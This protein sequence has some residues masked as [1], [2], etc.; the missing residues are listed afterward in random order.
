MLFQPQLCR[1]IQSGR[2]TQTRRLVKPGKAGA[3]PRCFYRIGSS[4]PLE[5]PM[6]LDE[7]DENQAKVI[8]RERPGRPPK[9]QI[10]RVLIT[11]V[12]RL[13]LR[14]L[15]FDAARAEGFPR[16]SA[17][18]A[19]WVRMH[20]GTWVRRFTHDPAPG[21][22]PMIEPPSEDALVARYD[23]RWGAVE[24]WAITF[25]LVESAYY[26]AARPERVGNDYVT[27]ERDEKGREVAMMTLAEVARAVHP[28]FLQTEETIGRFPEEAVHPGIIESWASEPR[29]THA[30]IK[31][32]TRARGDITEAEQ[33]SVDRRLLATEE[34]IRDR[35]SAAKGIARANGH[36][37]SN[38]IK[39]LRADQAYHR[40]PEAI[41]EGLRAVERAATPTSIREAKHAA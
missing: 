33:R 17:F 36:D 37:I 12:Q 27:S 38:E 10:G 4:Y 13:P 1:L 15:D 25:Q 31:E 28:S 34:A 39:A 23:K 2:K 6:R 24:V 26:L 21:I 7:A 9:K 32:R 20:D 35:I 8:L 18:K 19:Y 29:S 22:G 16:P 11:D 30:Q 41:E 40:A 5:R 14:E 3:A